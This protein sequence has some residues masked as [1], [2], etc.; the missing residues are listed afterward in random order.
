VK[1]FLIAEYYPKF[2]F[3]TKTTVLRDKTLN[4]NLLFPGGINSN[5]DYDSP[6]P[7]SS[8]LSLGQIS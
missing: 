2:L 6:M 5:L 3:Y 8:S 1:S 4:L 7:Y